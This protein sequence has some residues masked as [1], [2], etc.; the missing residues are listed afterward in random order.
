MLTL[1]VEKRDSK[2]SPENIRKTGKIPAVFYGPKE[3]STPVVIDAKAFQKIWKQAGESSVIILKDGS[4]EHEALIHETDIHPISGA[5]RHAD[6]Y[7]IEKG[8]KVSVKV[9]LVFSGVSSAVKDK[10][11]ILVKVLREIE[12]EAAPRDLPRE[13]TVD[14]SKLVELS[15]VVH[16]SDI[17]LPAG[18]TI[19]AEPTEVVAS[20]TVAKE[21]VEAPTTIDMSAI[22]VSDAKGKKPEE[23]AEGAAP[24]ADKKA[25]KK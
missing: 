18:V 6:F 8:K 12:V 19:K 2:L 20:V 5:V 13:L 7:V 15:D 1:N 16:A 21:E 25:E 17:A 9:Q 3:K 4:H 22:E 10:G 14:I 24:A 23:G 11:G